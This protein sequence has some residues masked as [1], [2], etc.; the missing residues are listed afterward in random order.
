VTNSTLYK[1][2]TYRLWY[3]FFSRAFKLKEKDKEELAAKLE[4]QKKNE[5]KGNDQVGE[6]DGPLRDKKKN[7]WIKS[8]WLDLQKAVPLDYDAVEMAKIMWEMIT[9]YCTDARLYEHDLKVPMI[10]KKVLSTTS[11]FLWWGASR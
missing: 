1:S 5:E 11:H 3:W 6:P 4:A 8:G 7:D 2:W 9:D 10:G